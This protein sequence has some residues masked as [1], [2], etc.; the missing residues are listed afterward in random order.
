MP[1]E[2]IKIE[3]YKIFKNETIS[4]KKG[5]NIFVGEN[6]SGKSTL[7]EALSIVTTGKINGFSVSRVMTTDFFNKDVKNEY[8][9]QVKNGK[10]PPPPEI[11]IEI[12][13]TKE[14]KYA[15]MKGQENSDNNKEAYGIKVKIAFDPTYEKTY[16]KMVQDAEVNE[17]PLEFY[18]I[19]YRDFRGD[20]VSFPLK[21]YKTIMIDTTKKD[22]GNILS[23]FIASNID[24]YLT[25]EARTQLRLAFRSN[26]ATSKESDAVQQLNSNLTKN[27]QFDG[28][29]VKLDLRESLLDAWKNEMTLS[30]DSMPFEN[31]GYGTQNSLKIDLVVQNDANKMDA[32]IMEEPENNL[33]FTNMA[34]IV[35]KIIGNHNKQ[36]FIS[37]HSSFIT[38][39]LGL[40]NVILIRNGK[41]I[42]FYGLPSDTQRFFEKATGYDT[43]R[44]ILAE[45]VILVEG[46]TDELIVQKAYK[47]SYSK[48]PL[49]DGI[50][51]F[52]V[53]SLSFLHFC[54]IAKAL[55]KPIRIL[56]DNDEK[57]K[58][59]NIQ[60]IID[61]YKDFGNSL[62]KVFFDKSTNNYSIEPSVLSA[63]EKNFDV[64]KKIVYRGKDKETV[65]KDRI[66]QYME[67]DKNKVEWAMRVF[68]S[69]VAIN[70]P[71]HI[72]VVIKF[73]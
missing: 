23:R 33:S 51:V 27:T 42:P 21:L 66:L 4:L 65:C 22:Y 10:T 39:K 19:T 15:P 25:E 48:S 68:E 18:K 34:K 43:L 45:K 9:T 59:G 62:V 46:P 8:L 44:F 5:I 6:D 2:K 49:E 20:G 47:D 30:V 50:D 7:L 55:N 3:N 41:T 24:E 35:G 12:Y 16:K 40:M 61:K 60:I 13:F 58:P 32:I 17:I 57:T 38:N 36:I 31:L 11:I 63:N 29:D 56:I 1:I 71:E 37:T 73:E 64:F 52:A 69:D 26:R 54:E 70:Y 72:K 14:E 53:G 67:N 28:K